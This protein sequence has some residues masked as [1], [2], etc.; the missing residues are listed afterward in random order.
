MIGHRHR[1][2]SEATQG[3]AISV[4]VASLD[5]FAPLAKTGVAVRRPNAGTAKA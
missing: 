1:E 2:R 4:N 5:C 3:S